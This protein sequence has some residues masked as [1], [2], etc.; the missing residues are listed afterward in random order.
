M[1][2]SDRVPLIDGQEVKAIL[3]ALDLKQ[4]DLAV[5]ENVSLRKAQ[6]RAANG[7]HGLAAICLLLLRKTRIYCPAH[8]NWRGIRKDANPHRAADP[9]KQAGLALLAD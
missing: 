9:K 8:G 1:G 3:K 6:D 7:L 4:A 5:L 2:K